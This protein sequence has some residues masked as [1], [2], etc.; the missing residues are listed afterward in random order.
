MALA[1]YLVE[2][3]CQ[4]GANTTVIIT[5]DTAHTGFPQVLRRRLAVGASVATLRCL[6]AKVQVNGVIERISVCRGL[7]RTLLDAIHTSA[8]SRVP[9]DRRG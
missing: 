9:C 6:G 1:A 4:D 8:Y 2:C 5:S 3:G 7:S